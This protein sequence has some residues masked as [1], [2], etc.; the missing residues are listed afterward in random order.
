MVLKTQ[1]KHSLLIVSL[2][3]IVLLISLS[4]CGSS[5]LSDADIERMVQQRVDT[6]LNERAETTQST[7]TTNTI[8]TVII[9]DTPQDNDNTI[10]AIY[11]TDSIGG[12]QAA[13]KPKKLIVDEALIIA[14]NSGHTKQRRE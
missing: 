1:A 3:A 13:F 8:S 7:M 11:A 10:A 5:N 2:I 6:A 9:D 14:E 12:T 4:A